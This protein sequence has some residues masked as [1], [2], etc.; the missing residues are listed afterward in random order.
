VLWEEILDV[1]GFV[2]LL[3]E[4]VWRINLIVWSVTIASVGVTVVV[5]DWVGGVVLELVLLIVVSVAVGE[6]VGVLHVL[7]KN[8]LVV[9]VDWVVVNLVQLEHSNL[10]SGISRSTESEVLDNSVLWVSGIKDFLV[11]SLIAV[12]EIVTWLVVLH[13]LGLVL[14]LEL[15]E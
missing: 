11:V 14:K 13:L 8:V 12:A 9:L 10:T 2:V 3:V 7:D 15:L 5:D 6:F 1:V 4:S